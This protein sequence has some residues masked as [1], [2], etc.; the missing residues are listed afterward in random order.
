MQ[1]VGFSLRRCTSS[2]RACPEEPQ[3]FAEALRMHSCT[4]LWDLLP[5]QWPGTDWGHWRIFEAI[6]KAV[7]KISLTKRSFLSLSFSFSIFCWIS[8]SL[9]GC[10]ALISSC[11]LAFSNCR[12]IIT[13]GDDKDILKAA[14]KCRH[15]VSK[16]PQSYW[17]R[18]RVLKT[19][20][21]PTF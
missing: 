5:Q 7:Y 19:A 8:L 10:W 21:A 1:A 20:T 12:R 13:A 18:G 15:I 17:I 6:K 11:L 3:G 14:G 16:Q 9:H 4:H 2:R